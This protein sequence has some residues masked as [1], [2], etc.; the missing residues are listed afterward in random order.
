MNKDILNIL[1]KSLKYTS[2]FYVN[3]LVSE[4][5]NEIAKTMYHTRRIYSIMN[6]DKPLYC[7]YILILWKKIKK[8]KIQ[9]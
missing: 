7:K 2:K 6:K 9:N 1:D 4:N 5:V 8:K 3:I